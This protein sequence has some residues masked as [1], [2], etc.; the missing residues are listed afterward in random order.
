MAVSG[1]V[2]TIDAANQPS[3]ILIGGKPFN[4][5]QTYTIAISDYLAGGGDNMGFFKA[6]KPR[7]TGVL[8]RTAIAD[9]I[10]AQTLQGKPLESRVE[11]R[12]KL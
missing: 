4:P 2:Y 7:G 1:A 6:L 10:K 5:A 3:N 12:V 8:V 11:G 9:Y